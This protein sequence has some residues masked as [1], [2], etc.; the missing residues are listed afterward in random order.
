MRAFDKA[1]IAA[2]L[3]AI[4][5]VSRVAAADVDDGFH[6]VVHPHPHAAKPTTTTQFG[7]VFNLRCIQCHDGNPGP[8]G[9]G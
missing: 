9:P 3:L 8:A 1:V 2:G 4:A 5:G 7:P 6:A